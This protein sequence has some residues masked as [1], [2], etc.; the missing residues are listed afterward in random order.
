VFVSYE[1]DVMF[2]GK[3]KTLAFNFPR[4]PTSTADLVELMTASASA[5]AARLA[6]LEY[7]LELGNP[8]HDTQICLPEFCLCNP[9]WNS[10]SDKGFSGCCSQLCADTP[11]SI[12]YAGKLTITEVSS[13]IETTLSIQISAPNVIGTW[14]S[15]NKQFDSVI[16]FAYGD[17]T[18]DLCTLVPQLGT[19]LSSENVGGGQKCATVLTHDFCV[20]MPSF[21]LS[22][23]VSCD[24]L[25]FNDDDD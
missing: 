9:Y 10:L 4:V 21:P 1:F 19:L 3:N 16:E 20:T 6:P 14:P 11:L 12:Y 8:Y 2:F 13:A 22:H 24:S 25:A 15:I 17:P 18:R 23:W 5:M 7:E